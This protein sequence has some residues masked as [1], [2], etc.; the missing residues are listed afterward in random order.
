MQIDQAGDQFATATV[1]YLR[2]IDSS[3]LS[4]CHKPVLTDIG[5]AISSEEVS[6]VPLDRDIGP[7]SYN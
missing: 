1:S 5:F 2:I 6:I 4:H 7:R 3:G